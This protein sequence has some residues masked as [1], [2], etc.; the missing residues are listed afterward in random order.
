MRKRI[1]RVVASV[2]IAAGIAVGSMTI[3]APAEAAPTTNYN[4]AYYYVCLKAQDQTI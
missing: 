2:A 3:T 4:C 1:R